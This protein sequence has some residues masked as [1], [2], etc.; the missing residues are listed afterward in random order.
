VLA[1]LAGAAWGERLTATDRQCLQRL[2]QIARAA[3]VR[4]PWHRRRIV[5]RRGDPVRRDARVGPA[6]RG[7]ASPAAARPISAW[8]C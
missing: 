8:P 2:A 6:P 1:R 3:Q 5:P 4:R 7:R